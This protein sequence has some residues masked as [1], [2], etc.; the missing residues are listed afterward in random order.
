MILSRRFKLLTLCLLGGAVGCMNVSGI[1]P[2][3]RHHSNI[4][5]YSLFRRPGN[6]VADLKDD[7]VHQLAK[8]LTVIED[9]IRRDGSITVKRPDVWGDA[10]MMSHLQEFEEQMK[11]RTLKFEETIQSFR[12]ESDFAKLAAS[13]GISEDT[14][15]AKAA[16]TDSTI[17]GFQTPAAADKSK[18]LDSLK[19][20]GTLTSEKALSL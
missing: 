10:G 7:P 19:Q 18:L 5:D 20:V 14:T 17:S 15:G 8:D 16:P 6:A 3:G 12:S 11:S 13:V 1:V 4:I 9:D 2:D